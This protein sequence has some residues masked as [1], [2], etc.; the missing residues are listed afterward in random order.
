MKKKKVGGS[1][2]GSH[3]PQKEVTLDPRPY[4]KKNKKG[5][6]RVT[7]RLLHLHNPLL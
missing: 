7:I 1:G 3:P 6:D 4:F 5:G 2:L